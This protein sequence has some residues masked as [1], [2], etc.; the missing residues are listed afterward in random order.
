M[1]VSIFTPSHNPQYI[2]ESYRYLKDQPYDEWVI[3]LNNGATS[4]SI[5]GD[6]LL[7][8][9]N[10]IIELTDAVTRIG[11]LKEVACSL[12]NSDILVELDHD[13]ILTPGAI[14]EIVDAFAQNSQASLVYSNCAEFN[15][16]EARS[17]RFYGSANAENNYDDVNGWAYRDYELDGFKYKAAVAPE[18]SPYHASLILWQP[19]HVRAYRKEAYIAVGGY[20][21]SM[22]VL[23]DSD[24]ICRLYEWG[25]F[26]HINK[27]L[28]LY[29]VDGNNSW[30]Q[31]NQEIQDNMKRIQESR[32]WGLAAAW[33]RRNDLPILDLGGRFSPE[34]GAFTVDLKEADISCDLNQRW[35]FEDSSIGVI[36]AWDIFEHL[37]DIIHTMSELH[38]VLVPGGYAFIEIPSTDGRGAFQDP[39]HKSFYNENSM[40]YYTRSSLA[41][42]I[43]N[44]TIR[45]KD[46]I[47]KTY[48][49]SKWHEDNLISYVKAILLCL[50]DGYRPHGEVLI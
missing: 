20:D 32:I 28:Y 36:K 42:Y 5:P 4:E 29:R 19:N 23:D 21:K 49:P 45:F 25:P 2:G 8:P 40:W 44:T 9:R 26:V 18:P 10:K 14:K 7:D 39:T 38:R 16:D 1:S 47:L 6:I 35:P 3:L 34:R 27:C 48:Y 15:N 46:I 33:S 24:L 13:D 30:L 37:D 43:D 22:N 12:C 17:Y 50:K 41:K 31:R 11:A